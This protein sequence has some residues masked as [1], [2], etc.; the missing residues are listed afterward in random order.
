M[1]GDLLRRAGVLERL[2]ALM[3]RGVPAAEALASIGA[4][5]RAVAV[6][7]EGRPVDEALLAAG[8]VDA[9]EAGLVR[10]GDPGR[11]LAL[12]GEELRARHEVTRTFRAAA[13]RP[14][15]KLAAVVVVFVGLTLILGGEPLGLP[16]PGPP[17]PW[18]GPGLPVAAQPPPPPSLAE[19]FGAYAAVG[20][21]LLAG[22][23]LLRTRAA[24]T[25]LERVGRD[26]PVI[27]TLLEL[28]VGAR[29]LRALGTALGAGLDLPRALERAR[30]AF[31]GRA[32]ARELEHLIA[33]A[34]EG[35]GLVSILG[36]APLELPTAQW[37]AGHAVGRADPS[38]EL[39]ALAAS[40]EQRLVRECA[41][42]SPVLGGVA[43]LLIVIGVGSSLVSVAGGAR[44]L[45]AFF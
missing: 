9:S 19:R 2:G 7:R 41:R 38:R 42:W 10:A 6:A 35:Q 23:A 21:V 17:T 28:E 25:P 20:L 30:D 4:G 32:T 33:A 1:T 5:P 39:L 12:L 3:R 27:S 11:G 24:R 31:V 37:V 44:G 26:L 14:F 18:G 29:Y 34:R 22:A 45:L 16:E 43:D 36:R 40:Y 13:V 15:T 8:L